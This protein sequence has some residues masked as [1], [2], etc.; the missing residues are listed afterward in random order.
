MLKNMTPDN[1]I[2]ISNQIEIILKSIE[3]R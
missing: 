1:Y 2:E 3:R